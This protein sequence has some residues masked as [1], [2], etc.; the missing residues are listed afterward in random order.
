MVS[1]VVLDVRKKLGCIALHDRSMLS[2]DR[3]RWYL[4]PSSSS[5]WKFGG[6]AF[7]RVK[8]LKRGGFFSLALDTLVWAKGYVL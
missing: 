8:S 5:D 4:G 3:W 6:Q 2:I 1:E 7:R